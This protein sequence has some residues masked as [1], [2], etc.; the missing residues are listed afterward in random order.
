M[1]DHSKWTAEDYKNAIQTL[2][3]K[4]KLTPTRAKMLR[5]QYDA[6]EHTLIEP[7]L[8]AQMG[9][10]GHKG[11]SDYG[12]LGKLLGAE[13]LDAGPESVGQGW[14][15]LS[16]G[17]WRENDDDRWPGERFFWA[18]RPALAQAL[19]ELGLVQKIPVEQT[20]AAPEIEPELGDLPPQTYLEGATHQVI[21]NAYERNRTARQAC[22]DYHGTICSVCDSDL[23][24]FYGPIA[25]DFIHVHHLKPLS[26]IGAGYSVN[27]QTDLLP[28]CPNCHAMLHRT[29]PPLTVEQLREMIQEAH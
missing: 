8:T 23:G 24:E 6:S 14:P 28:V 20:A 19:E 26:E 13:L 27:P 22:V 15:F 9:W 16:S 3:L 1:M 25:Y 10:S 7:E 12:K 2:N 21:V 5:V 11:N 29:T 17:K 18:M 4:G